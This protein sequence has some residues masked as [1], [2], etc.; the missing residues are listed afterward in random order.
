MLKQIFLVLLLIPI[1][2]FA[3]AEQIPDYNKPYAPIFFNKPIYSWT[4]KV[5]ITIIAPSW[6]TG[7]NLIDSI[8]G[9][10]NYSVNVYTNNH[11]LKQYKLYETD[12]SSG[13]FTGKIILTGFLH[14]ANGDGKND[15][16]P[17]TLGEGP[18]G[19]YLQ[20]EEDSGIT[21]S[22]EFAD[23]VV[24]IESAK[25]EW[26]VGD[27]RIVDV[28]EES[29]KIKLFERDMNLNPESIDTINIEVFSENDNAGIK[30]EIAETTEDSGIFEGIISIVKDDKSSGNRLYALP[31]SQITAKYT[32][33]TLPKPYNTNDDLD[34]L[35][36]EIVI[37]NIPTIERLNMNE[38]GILGQTGELI[39][40]L[41]IGQTG[42]IFSKVKNTIDF[43]QEFAYIVQIK[44][45]DN[46]VISLS[47]VTG[48]TIPL[49]EL[50][51]SVSWMPQEP[52]KYS[53]ERFVWNSIQGAIPLTESVSTEIFIQ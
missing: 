26:N 47:W 39:E 51:M 3:F 50:G 25:I 49:Q 41:E 46:N 36:Q 52:G 8:G 28:T 32:D 45:Q 33:R 13:I 19:G 11:Q 38:I 2:Q 31:Y 17:R 20:N 29:A 16:N 5:E 1:T 35:A 43:T 15:T 6:N 4:E 48:K 34:I 37:S 30:L 24:L 9:D 53:I 18:N 21:V 22:F 10:P 7:I 23:G 42:M 44:N 14:D 27:L 12:P 40:K